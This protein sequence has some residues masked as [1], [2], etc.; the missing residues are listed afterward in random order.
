MK[1]NKVISGVFWKFAER[2]GAQGV[3]LIVS[4]ILARLIA[5]EEYGII[6][7]TTIFIAISNV[8]VESGLGTALIQKKDADDLDFSS[9]FYCNI[10][11]S[12][13]VY[14]MIFIFAPLI[15][16]FYNSE[17]LVPVLRVLRNYNINI[18]SK[19]CS[20]CICIKKYDI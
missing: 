10:V 4:I 13:I 16:N 5:P 19:K 15:A 2:I 12:I 11:I 1:K 18:R 7:L 20:K 17:I 6:A 14:L 8:F 3:S 9:V